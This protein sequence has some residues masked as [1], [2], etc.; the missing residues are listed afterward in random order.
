MNFKHISIF[1]IFFIFG[2]FFSPIAF[3]TPL[4]AQSI[5]DLKQKIEERNANIEKLEKEIEQYK[6]EVDAVGKQAK[7][8]QGS[9]K[10]LDLTQKKL[11]T[12][13]KVTENKISAA[14]YTLEK[15]NLEIKN[16]E[17]S[18]ERSLDSLGGILRSVNENDNS[19]L[20]EILLTNRSLSEFWN[21]VDVMNKLQ[22]GLD[23]KMNILKE[24][25]KQ[26]EEKRG[27]YQKTKDSLAT[28]K[29]N[30]GDQK[31]IVDISKN[32]KQSL[33]KETQNKE[34]NFKKT[35]DSKIALKDAFEQEL[36]AFESQLKIAIDPNSYAKAQKGVLVW[37]LDVVRIT[38]YFGDTEFSRT[39]AYNGKGHNG[40]DFGTPI[41]TPV[42]SA[43][44]GVVLG[45]GDTDVVCKG[46]SYGK[47]VLVQHDNGLSSVYGHLSLV[48]AKQGQRVSAG[49]AIAYSGNSGYSTGPHLHLSVFASQGVK[50]MDVKSKV[51]QGTYTM[52]VADLKAYLDPLSYL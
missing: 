6:T 21:D 40:I 43:Q 14:N 29:G 49:E 50:I 12:D 45:T 7:T 2:L 44:S 37:P 46:A 41:G 33:L 8:L 17:N 47:W 10:S 52:P 42:K 39:G 4:N 22:T 11:S 26:L 38:Q 27:E 5:D 51:C 25:K 1:I 16:A 20:I 23:E 30:L 3:F 35:L 18:L 9:V 19:T 36:L 15:V 24:L 32:E 31:K 48:K 28:L 34:S 13:I